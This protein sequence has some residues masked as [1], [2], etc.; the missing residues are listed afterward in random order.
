MGHVQYPHP[1]R[2]DPLENDLDWTT[3]KRPAQKFYKRRWFWLYVIPLSI[4]ASLVILVRGPVIEEATLGPFNG[5]GW[6]QGTPCV[7]EGS[8][9][10]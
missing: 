5:D 6:L 1:S 8:Q 9:M 2:Q 10:A 7:Q 3:G 4:S